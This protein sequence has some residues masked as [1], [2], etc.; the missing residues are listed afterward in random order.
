MSVKP[1]YP[2]SSSS[3]SKQRGVTTVKKVK[4]N[5]T[6]AILTILKRELA[7]IKEEAQRRWVKNEDVTLRV[8]PAAKNYTATIGIFDVYNHRREIKLDFHEE[9][10][11]R[12]VREWHKVVEQNYVVKDDIPQPRWLAEPTT[13]AF[14]ILDYSDLHDL[15]R[16][17]RILRESKQNIVVKNVP[18]K[19]RAFNLAALQEVQRV[20]HTVDIHDHSVQCRPT[21]LGKRLRSGTLE[22]VLQCAT[23]EN[24]KILNALDLPMPTATLEET[25]FTTDL[26][27]WR[28]TMGELNCPRGE[29]YPTSKFRWALVT[30]KGGLHWVHLDNDGFATFIHVRTGAKWWIIATPKKG[31]EDAAEFAHLEKDYDASLPRP[32]LWD[33]EA[34][35]LTENTMLLMRPNTRHV[36]LTVDHTIVAGGYFYS[37]P[38]L[39]DSLKAFIHCFNADGAV[40]NSNTAASRPALQRILSFFYV[41]LVKKGVHHETDEYHHLPNLESSHGCQE[42]LVACVIGVTM[43]IFDFKAYAGGIGLDTNV[44]NRRERE[45]YMYVRGLAYAMVEWLDHHYIVQVETV[46]PNLTQSKQPQSSNDILFAIGQFLGDVACYQRRA[47]SAQID[48]APGCNPHLLENYIRQTFSINGT[49][50]SVYEG[51]CARTK[52]IAI[53]GDKNHRITYGPIFVDT[54]HA[55]KRSSVEAYAVKGI[56]FILSWT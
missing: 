34:V 42:F 6:P 15:P 16:V 22:Q 52:E 10:I 47:K 17:H 38:C 32:D 28:L 11:S 40:T 27:S 12:R 18:G 21:S 33:Y 14:A 2:R 44:L 9:F 8:A 35:L 36:V 5:A 13:S 56:Q 24:G 23:M 49:S 53:T 46:Q 37:T 43:I 3:K 45:Q 31:H 30:T 55:N 25:C 26:V 29:E 39:T 48:G 4:F 20:D 50:N 1:D 7:M 41:G 54:W 51:Y 19:R